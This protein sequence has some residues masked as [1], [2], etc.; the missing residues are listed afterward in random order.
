MATSNEG[1]MKQGQ[2][3][4]TPPIVS[5]QEWDAARQQ[6]L[7]RSLP[8]LGRHDGWCVHCEMPFSVLHAALLA[9]CHFISPRFSLNRPRPFALKNFLNLPMHTARIPPADPAPAAI[10]AALATHTG[11]IFPSSKLHNPPRLNVAAGLP[12][13]A[14]PSRGCNS[15]PPSR[16][17]IPQESIQT[18]GA[19]T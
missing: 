13:V 8:F 1:I 5:Q 19:E 14:S 9:C 3:I 16:F 18:T 10:A 11:H 4:N 17:D 15:S 7:P 6:L 12:R 2:G